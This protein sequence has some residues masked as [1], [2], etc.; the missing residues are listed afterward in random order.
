[1]I[2][3]RDNIIPDTIGLENNIDK[4]EKNIMKIHES[5]DKYVIKN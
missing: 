2:S 4:Y 1:M 5:G 3:Q